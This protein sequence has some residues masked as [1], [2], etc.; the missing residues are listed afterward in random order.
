MSPSLEVRDANGRW[1]TAIADLGFPSGKDKSLVIE[2]AGKF[3]TRDHRVRIRTNL[4][5]YWDQ[6]IV[7]QEAAA[8]RVNAAT[9]RRTTSSCSRET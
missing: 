2:L 9:A 7:E 5:I 4:Q 3:P 1:M 6:A 8:T